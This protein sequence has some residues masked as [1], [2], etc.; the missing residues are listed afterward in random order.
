VALVRLVSDSSQEQGKPPP[1]TPVSDSEQHCALNTGSRTRSLTAGAADK[2]SIIAASAIGPT[3]LA[4]LLAASATVALGGELC[5]ASSTADA[6]VLSSQVSVQL[7]DSRVLSQ[8][9]RQLSQ[10]LAG[11]SSED[12]QVLFGTP[13]AFIMAPTQEPPSQQAM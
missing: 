3:L 9:S 1:G 8:L 11:Q 7:S 12:W 13:A 2:D 6:Q 5:P 4:R 10:L